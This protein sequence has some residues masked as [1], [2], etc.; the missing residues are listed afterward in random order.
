MDTKNHS[1]LFTDCLFRYRKFDKNSFD[2]LKNNRLYFSVPIY[3]NDPNDCYLY[4]AIDNVLCRIDSDLDHMDSYIKLSMWENPF[5]SSAAKKIWQSQD[6]NKFIK[7]FK[8]YVISNI[9]QIRENMRHNVKVICFSQCY[10][11]NLMWSH[12]ADSHRGFV[13]AYDKQ[14]IVS[15]KRFD[16]DDT[17]LDNK[18]VLRPVTYTD[19][20]SDITDEMELYFKHYIHVK[21]RKET[22][23]K[24]FMPQKQLR[25]LLFLKQKEWSYEEEW[26]LTCRLVDLEDISP[27]HYIVCKPKAIIVGLNCDVEAGK[28]L[29]DYSVVSGI[30]IFEM[31]RDLSSAKLQLILSKY[32]PMDQRLA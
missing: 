6:K 31:K 8:E 32:T 21:T 15:A 29:Y 4:I 23:D 22:V 3:F 7:E 16:V 19:S 26:R 20:I 11:S 25:D 17:E 9:Q 18:T 10:D 30:P 14:S 12:Y 24:N 1:T 27:L 2:A 28:L 5:I 13:I